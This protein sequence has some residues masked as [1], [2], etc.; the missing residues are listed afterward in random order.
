MPRRSKSIVENPNGYILLVLG[1][2]FLVV[3]ILS[4]VCI[5]KCSNK[6]EPF[7]QSSGIQKPCDLFESE[8]KFNT[9]LDSVYTDS[10][11]MRPK[12]DTELRD[13]L[14][15]AKQSGCRVRVTGARHTGDGLVTQTNEENIVVVS[16]YDYQPDDD[17]WRMKL[18]TNTP[19][20]KAPGGASLLD[21]MAFIR[22]QGY[23]MKSMTAGPIFTLAGIM[24]NTVHGGDHNMGFI[25]E[26]MISARVMLADG[27]I[28]IISDP[29]E[30]AHWRSSYGLL[31]I[32]TAIEMEVRKDQGMLMRTDNHN[33]PQWD[34]QTV[35][36]KL[37]PFV[38]DYDG[39]E[40]FFNPN[41]DSMLGLLYK[42]DGNPSY[43]VDYNTLTQFYNEYKAGPFGDA[44]WSGG[45]KSTLSSIIN[46]IGDL[47]NDFKVLAQTLTSQ[48]MS[49]PKDAFRAA[50]SKTNDG[51]WLQEQPDITGFNSLARI[52]P[53]DKTF[54]ALDVVRTVWRKWNA[55]NL[56]QSQF[57]FNLPVEWRFMK[58][59]ES[60]TLVNLPPGD[61][62]S[63]EIVN[64][65]DAGNTMDYA[66]A[67]ME[68]EMEWE[69]LGGNIHTGK[70]YGFA[71]INSDLPP[72]P[73]NKQS[74]LDNVFTQDQINTFK[75]QMQKYDPQG[76]FKAG[77][78]CR[79]FAPEVNVP[80]SGKLLNGMKC[81]PFGKQMCASG[82]CCTE[83]GSCGLN[84][85]TCIASGVKSKY[86]DCDRSCECSD[87]RSCEWK[88]RWSDWLYKK[89][90]V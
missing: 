20:V 39:S 87:G 61:Y 32:L 88:W 22:P 4:I 23:L 40:W 14:A 17:A 44:G 49:K 72:I 9:W 62:I 46:S 76:L 65:K 54:E 36:D 90:C 80:F 15:K 81:T 82:C 25:N 84:M 74:T 3:I 13:I 29:S 5:C 51:Y 31:G 7:S 8:Y 79:W 24:A 41:D 67:F 50:A 45:P 89:R 16:L 6:D 58:V 10:P 83:I 43:N 35:L 73:F 47:L 11:I 28:Q 66:D 69:K 63:I 12:N 38:D 60:S 70:E 19:S 85:N 59:R 27:S 34:K 30:I 75:T 86:E 77:G 68:L 53:M 37:M 33:F 48:G 78:A 71:K 1:L 57:Y 55:K 64:C 26:T 2:L 52:I 21:V 18:D 56:G 42:F